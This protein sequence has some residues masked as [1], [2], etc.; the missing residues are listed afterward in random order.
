[1]KFLIDNALSPALAAFLQEACYDAIHVR[2]IGLQHV[3]DEVMFEYGAAED[4]IV[5]SA[6]ADFRNVLAARSSRKPS[7]IQFRL[8]VAAD[9]MHWREH[10]SRICPDSSTRWRAAAL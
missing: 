5:I 10:C 7:V 6:D 1:M 8:R 2:S 9:P 3:D 4:R